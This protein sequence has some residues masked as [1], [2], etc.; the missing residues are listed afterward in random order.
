LL[1]RPV[2]IPS[3]NPQLSAAPGSSQRYDDDG[4]LVYS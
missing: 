1:I 3:G 4:Q 2:M